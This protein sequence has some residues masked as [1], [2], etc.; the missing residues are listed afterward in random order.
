MR[1]DLP[2]RRGEVH[3]PIERLHDDSQHHDGSA[4]DKAT[5]KCARSAGVRKN[6]GRAG[7]KQAEREGPLKQTVRTPVDA[8]ERRQ[9]PG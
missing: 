3:P 7:G 9:G 8:S 4:R 6:Q 2:G 5:Q 1:E